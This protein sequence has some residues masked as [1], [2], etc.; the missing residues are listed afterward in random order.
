LQ[1]VENW[2]IEAY[3]HSRGEKLF[4]QVRPTRGPLQTPERLDGRFGLVA[5]LYVAALLSP[6]LVLVV[7]QWPGLTSWPVALGLLGVVG[8][9]L[10]AAVA[11]IVARHGEFVAWFDSAWI[12]VLVP[13]LGVLP[14][15]VY[16]VPHKASSA[17]C[18]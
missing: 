3:F 5:G 6:A 17:S 14:M 18:F 4:M 9:V 11:R 13:V 7:V 10:A 2:C 8:A 15:G 1:P 12:A 16:P